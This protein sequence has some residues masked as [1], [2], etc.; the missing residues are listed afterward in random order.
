MAIAGKGSSY[1]GRETQT[2]GC[3]AWLTSIVSSKLD[4]QMSPWLWLLQARKALEIIVPGPCIFRKS[5]ARSCNGRDREVG[6]I[7]SHPHSP[8]DLG[9]CSDSGVGWGD[10][11][12]LQTQPRPRLQRQPPVSAQQVIRAGP[13]FPGQWPVCLGRINVVW[14]SLRNPQITAFKPQPARGLL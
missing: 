14:F 10:P 1:H 9:C 3:Q 13:G 8:Q 5:H 7:H 12:H 11:Y 4:K 6:R 2:F